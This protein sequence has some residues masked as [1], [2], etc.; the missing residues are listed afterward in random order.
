MSRR[1]IL[2]CAGPG[3]PEG[4]HAGRQRCRELRR[5]P[6]PQVRR[7]HQ[8]H[9]RDGGGLGRGEVVSIGG[10]R[11]TR[12]AT[13][14]PRAAGRQR[15]D[16]RHRHRGHVRILP[17]PETVATLL[18]IYDD[19]GD[20]ARS[21]PRSSPAGI[22]PATLEM[23]DAP[24]HPGGRGEL[25][26]GY[27]HGRRGG[28]HR[29]GGRPGR[30]TERAGGAHQRDLHGQRLPQRPRGERTPPSATV[31]WAGRRGAFGAV[32]RLAP[33]YLVTDCTVPRTKLPQ[34][35]ARWRRSEHMASITATSS[36]RATATCTRCSSS[37]PAIR[38]RWSAFRR[39]AGRSCR[40]AS[41]GRDHHRRARRRH[42]K[43]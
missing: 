35:L 12:P 10:S 6:L 32:A 11:S 3:Q 5:P 43:R 28:A 37:I 8:P 39:P 42:G 22:T 16:A 21:V 36:T 38:I 41:T 2:L 19:V 17:M 20:A 31:L 25:P 30:R 9:P 23:M 13:I 18:V 15:G 4:R 33:N 26:C 34:A 24:G 40:P 1:W 27:P 7:H 14:L 29:R